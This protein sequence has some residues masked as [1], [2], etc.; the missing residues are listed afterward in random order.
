M[1][2]SN[3]PSWLNDVIGGWQISDINT[4]HTGF[5]YNTRG[6][7]IPPVKFRTPITP[8]I[9]NGSRAAIK[10]GIHTDPATGQLQ[11]FANPTAAIGAFAGPLGLQSGNRNIL[12]GPRFSDFDIGLGK[13]FPIKERLVMELRADAFNI[14]NHPDFGLPH[15][16]FTDITNPSAFGVITATSAPRQLQVAFRL[17]F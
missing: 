4:W 13:H 8:G 16:G 15:G 2:G 7:C 1:L 6:Q 12:R 14:F 10:T 3:M 17:D 5:A 9:F 11:I